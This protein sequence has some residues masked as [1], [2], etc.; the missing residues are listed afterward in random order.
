MKNLIEYDEQVIGY[1]RDLIEHLKSEIER[2][3]KQDY[4]DFVDIENSIY[5]MR[6]YVDL[7]NVLEKKDDMELYAITLGA[8]GDL[9]IRNVDLNIIP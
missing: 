9:I 5:S 6:D 1:A 2:L 8:M 7:I 4:K 3:R